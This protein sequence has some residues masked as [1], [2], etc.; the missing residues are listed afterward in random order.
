MTDNKSDTQRLP[1]R[2][3]EPFLA[4]TEL[5]LFHVLKKIVEEHGG[6]ISIEN[7]VSNGACVSIV[8]PLVGEA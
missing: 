1:Y 5:A 8:L 6:H 3:R 2:L 7:N 4:T